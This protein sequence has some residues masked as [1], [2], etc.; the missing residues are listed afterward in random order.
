[1]ANQSETVRVSQPGYGAVE[2]KEFIRKH[3]WRAFSIT[4][5]LLAVLVLTHYVSPSGV[6]KRAQLEAIN[7]VNKMSLMDISAPEQQAEDKVAPPP[8][9]QVVNTGPAARA[10]NPVPVPDA[11]VTPDMQEFATMDVMSRASAEGGT[12]EDLGGFASNIDFDESEDLNVQTKEKE[13]APDEFIPV[14]K[15]PYTD[16]SELQKSVVYPD[17]ARKAGIEGRVVLRVLVEKDG[18]VRK[19]LVQ[20]SDSQ[21]LNQ[22]AIDAVEKATF[23]PAQQ[24]GNPVMVWVSIPVKFSLR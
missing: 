12:G 3:T 24:N 10:G 5:I 6:D 4:A 9:Q 17:M 18:S 20:Q 16:M 13:P 23:T 15:Q 11:Q 19:V 21:L 2:L 8:D 22:A 14:E 7:P 1:M